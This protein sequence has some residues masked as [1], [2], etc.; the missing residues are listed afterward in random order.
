MLV[1][2][3]VLVPQ[4]CTPVEVKFEDT[5][6][7]DFF[8]E[9]VEAGRWPEEFGRIWIHTHPASSAQPSSTDENT[10]E[11]VFGTTDWAVMFILA[12]GGQTYARLRYHT[13]PGCEVSLDVEVDYSQSFE[14]ADHQAWQAEYDRCVEEIA[15]V[16]T[17]KEPA[18]TSASWDRRRL[19]PWP[20]EDETALEWANDWPTGDYF[21]C[22]CDHYYNAWLDYAQ[23]EE[24]PAGGAR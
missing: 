15:P 1:E 23:P 11:R 2:D 22:Y 19:D 5:A 14:A 20:S 21:D 8:D 16:A 18:V 13:G 7:A 9:Q 10:F 24:F 6:I 4:K 17:S 3:V 12:R